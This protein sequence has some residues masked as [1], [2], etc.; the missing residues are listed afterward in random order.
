MKK[1]LAQSLIFHCVIVIILIITS[2][3][4]FARKENIVEETPI[5]VE[6]MP[7]I[8]LG[9]KT[10]VKPAPKSD[11]K[12]KPP[13][14]HQVKPTPPKP[15]PKPTPIPLVT[16]KAVTPQPQPKKVE[17]KPTTKPQ[18]KKDDLSKMLEDLDK[19]DKS[20]DTDDLNK[21]LKDM[22]KKPS[23]AT[24]QA[25]KNTDANSTSQAKFDENAPVSQSDINSVTK[26][27]TDQLKGCWSPPA[28]VINA[29][30]LVVRVDV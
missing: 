12:P 10:N 22:D 2:W 1:P 23:K 29:Q 17:P 14:A 20:Q 28:G 26:M 18:P 3:G 21:M 6:L 4:I 11:E 19:K 27:I 15:Q 16:P 5:T 24:S 9:A 13:I 8:P 7:N 25:T 30:G